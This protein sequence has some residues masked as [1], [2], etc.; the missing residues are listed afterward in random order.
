MLVDNLLYD[1]KAET[2]SFRLR[3]DVGLERAVQTASG[4]PA[5]P[6]AKRERDFVVARVEAI[7]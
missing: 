1:G 2:R 3:R 6:S 7:W 5:P 4:K